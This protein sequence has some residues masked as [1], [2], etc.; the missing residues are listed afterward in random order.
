MHS[1]WPVF[2]FSSI[3]VCLLPYC[4]VFVESQVSLCLKK[5]ADD[6]WSPQWGNK[7]KKKKKLSCCDSAFVFRYRAHCT[8][9]VQTDRYCIDSFMFCLHR[10]TW[11]LNPPEV[12]DA[13]LQFAGWG[14]RGQQ[15]VRRLYAWDYTHWIL[16]HRWSSVRISMASQIQIYGSSQ[17]DR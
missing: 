16:A 7:Q 13:V 17:W 12:H 15:L 10:E 5:N 2:S 4:S 11:P 14:P 3:Y 9:S 8:C 6:W 1:A